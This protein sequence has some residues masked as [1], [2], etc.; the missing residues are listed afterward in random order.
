MTPLLDEADSIER[1][2]PRFITRREM[3]RGGLMAT[4]LAVASL[5]A[6]C[7]P[8][9]STSSSAGAPAAAG[10]TTAPGANP[11]GVP[12][13]AAQANAA[14]PAVHPE[15]S[16][17]GQIV[18]NIEDTYG[19]AAGM[20]AVAKDYMA[21]YPKVQVTVDP[22]PIEGYLDWAK[23]QVIGGTKASFLRDPSAPDLTAAGKFVDFAPEY[24]KINPYTEQKWRDMFKPGTI[25]PDSATGKFVQFNMFSVYVL[26]YYNRTLWDQVGLKETPKTWS[27][28]IKVLDTFKQAGITATPM[29]GDLDGWRRMGISWLDRITAD[30][31]MRDSINLVRAQ[32]GDWNFT[33]GVDDTWKF[34]PTDPYNDAFGK[35][36]RNQAR[37]IQAFRDGKLKVDNPAYRDWWKHLK[38]FLGYLQPGYL[39]VSKDTSRQLFLTSKAAL[40]L[41]ASWFFSQFEKFMSDPALGLKKFEYGTFNLVDIDDSPLVQAP[42]RAIDNPAGYWVVPKKTEQQNALEIDFLMFLSTPKNAAKL[43]EIVLQDPKGD[44][45]GPPTVIGVELTQ[46]W[47]DRFSVIGGRGQAENGA[48]GIHGLDPESQREWVDLAQQYAADKLNEDDFFKR[49][50]ASTMNAVPRVVKAQGYDL[51]HPEK[52]PEPPA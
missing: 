27:Q 18:A 22:K 8:P 44:L 9:A 47:K 41:D 31:Y 21:L 14:T 32:P 45:T 20:E 7:S 13:A 30:A 37:M 17:E 15:L 3:L 16:R 35:V 50:Q 6:A 36:T 33:P 19:H 43:T 29:G 28:F 42:T 40:W 12:P 25:Q 5:L 23:A 11:T 26:W 1:R 52:K 48:P 39:G 24:E 49:W 46:V 34:D 2:L 38:Q 10:A 51:D 4:G